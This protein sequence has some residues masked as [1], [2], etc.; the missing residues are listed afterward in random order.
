MNMNIDSYMDIDMVTKTPMD[1][2][3]GPNMD[4]DT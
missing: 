3:M 2:E 4:V 1:M